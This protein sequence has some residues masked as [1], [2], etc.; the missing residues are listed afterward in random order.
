MMAKD[1]KFYDA[2]AQRESSGSVDLTWVNSY[3]DPV[4][5]F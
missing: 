1:K 4:L 3:K 2:L 5:Q